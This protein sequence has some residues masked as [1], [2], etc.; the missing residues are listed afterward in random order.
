MSGRLAVLAL[1]LATLL[2]PGAGAPLSRRG[3]RNKLL[4]VS[5]DGFRWNYDQDVHTPNLDAMA[6]EGVKARYMTPAFVTMTSP[7]HFTLVTGERAPWAGAWGQGGGR[8][9]NPVSRAQSSG[10]C[11]GTEGT[12]EGMLS[13]LG[14]RARPGG[15]GASASLTDGGNLHKASKC[16]VVPF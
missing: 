13:S 1:A 12:E 3:S 10:R 14:D 2:A 8:G 4:L 9:G 7:C 5:F 11:T 6:L 16:P 15:G